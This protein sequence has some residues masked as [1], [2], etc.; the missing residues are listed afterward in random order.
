MICLINL[1]FNVYIPVYTNKFS[2]DVKKAHK[3]RKN[4]EKFKIIAE[5]LISGEKLDDLHNDHTLIY[6]ELCW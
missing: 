3:R 2:K 6:R 1:A 4:L 5:V